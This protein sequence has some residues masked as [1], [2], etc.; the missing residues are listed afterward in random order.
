MRSFKV[1]FYSDWIF[2]Y[3]NVYQPSVNVFDLLPADAF[4]LIPLQTCSTPEWKS[5][6]RKKFLLYWERGI[7]M[8]FFT[9]YKSPVGYYR[10]EYRNDR[11]TGLHYTGQAAL[12][13]TKQQNSS[14]GNTDYSE[15]AEQI[16]KFSDKVHRELSEYFSGKRKT[17]DIPFEIHGTEFQKKV[18]DALCAIPYGQTRTYKETA[19]AV[20]SPKAF[21]A[22]GMANHNN[23]IAILIPCH[24]V[25]GV[26]GKLTGYADGLA[27]KEALLNLEQI[28]K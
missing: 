1:S 17:F 5:L 7:A 15:Y 25:I 13:P 24:R 28:S 22:V 10:I 20:G 4:A 18:W 14:T 3:Y 21:R 2:S 27:V 11:L 6:S 9:F 8:V 12:S 26:N 16:T 23:P 19:E